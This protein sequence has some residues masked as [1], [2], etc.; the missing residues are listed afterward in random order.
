MI[1]SDH[2]ATWSK[3]PGSGP[4]RRITAIEWRTAAETIVAASGRGL[5][6][7]DCTVTGLFKSPRDHYTNVILF[8]RRHTMRPHF[9]IRLEC[10]LFL[11]FYAGYPWGSQAQIQA[12]RPDDRSQRLAQRFLRKHGP[13]WTVRLSPDKSRVESVFGPGTRSYG[14]KPEQAART[15]LS[16]DADLFGLRKD[17]ADLRVLSQHTNSSSGQVEFQQMVG[18]LPVENARVQV[19]LSRDG[20]V[21]QVVNRYEPVAPKGIAA[22]A[23]SREQATEAAI[24][25]FLRT[26]PEKPPS[27]RE[28]RAPVA[29]PLPRSQL[30]LKGTPSVEDVYFVRQGRLVRAYKITVI[31]ARPSGTKEFIVDAATGEILRT[32]DGKI[33]Q[34]VTG[35]AQVFNPNPVA[36]LNNNTI[37]NTTVPSTNPNPYY[38]VQLTDL[39]SPAAGPYVLNGPFAVVQD[40]EAP[41]HAPVSVTGT[42]NFVFQS[43]TDDFGDTMVYYTVDRMQRYIQELGFVDVN[44]RPTAVDS[45]GDRPRIV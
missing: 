26:T 42:P 21:L 38:T 8:K 15:F 33:Q 3:V 13:G 45:R 20:R 22:P 37:T 11:L 9:M 23:L 4:V 30:Q 10:V 39:N 25:E 34:N 18:G 41:T 1:S 6:R 44:N 36:S 35:T 16:D 14:E 28:R 17:L 7:V 43:N 29:V 5:W 31:A 40:I 27:L 19:S 32:K 24:T 2:G 12:Q